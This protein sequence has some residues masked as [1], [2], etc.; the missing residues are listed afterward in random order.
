[1]DTFYDT[2]AVTK[3]SGDDF[4]QKP[5]EFLKT[6]YYKHV[7]SLGTEPVPIGDPLNNGPR[8]IWRAR[9]QGLFASLLT[10]SAKQWFDART[11]EGV[12]HEW[13]AFKAE[14]IAQFGAQKHKYHARAKL[15]TLSKS[16]LETVRQYDTRIKLLVDVAWADKHVDIRTFKQQDTLVRGLPP[17][18]KAYATREFDN[19]GGRTHQE[20]VTRIDS[21]DAVTA[22]ANG[23]L[24][25]DPQFA[26]LESKVD[27]LTNALQ[28][29]HVNL[30][31]TNSNSS[32]PRQSQNSY[33]NF[34]KHCK[35]SGHTISQCW[36]KQ[37]EEG[38][39][40]DQGKKFVQKS[41]RPDNREND[42]TKKSCRYCKKSGHTIDECWA[43]QRKDKNQSNQR[44]GQDQNRSQ[45][46]HEA[47]HVEQDDDTYEY[48]SVNVASF[49]TPNSRTQNQK[50]L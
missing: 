26:Q 20:V 37:R 15:E 19:M 5:E 22:S 8:D 25:A 7:H 30:G 38:K 33:Q 21:R 27:K 43:K 39:Q 44:R 10:G 31:K 11:E 9:R 12:I 40:P 47:N 23:E 14:F 35:K 24:L 1:M 32:N 6:I 48:E 50:N 46:S 13:I 3:F 17:H 16:P 2:M 42:R 34:C 4:T 41:T 18:L 45:D 36:T 29:M 28:T 49:H